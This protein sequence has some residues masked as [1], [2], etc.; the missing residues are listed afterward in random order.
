M[1]ADKETCSPVYVK[2]Y[3]N[4]AI[5]MVELPDGYARMTEMHCTAKLD[6]YFSQLAKWHA[7]S[8]ST[9]GIY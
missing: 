4:H 3:N 8:P 5:R 6:S 7:C 1:G 2:Q 9:E